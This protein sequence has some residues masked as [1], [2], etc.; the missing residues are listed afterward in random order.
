M[1]S[2]II[3]LCCAILFFLN[4]VSF[5]Q[6]DELK[7]TAAPATDK[8]N[9]DD[10]ATISTLQ[11][12]AESMKELKERIAEQ[13]LALDRAKT[14]DQKAAVKKDLEILNKRYK[15]LEHDLGRVAAGVNLED[16][17]QVGPEAGDFTWNEEL[18]ELLWPI[19]QELKNMTARP[20][21]IERLRSELLYYDKAMEATQKAVANLNKCIQ[22]TD[23]EEL[24]QRLEALKK[25]WLARKQQIESQGDVA[26][27]E[28]EERMRE[29]TSVVESAQTI[30]RSFFK[31]RGQNLAFAVI[32]FVC[33]LI[34]F[35][36]VHRLIYRFS[37][38]HHPAKRNFYIRV[39]DVVYHF[40]TFIAAGGAL[41]IVL[42]GSGDWVLLSLVI[43]FLLGILWT[44]RQ[45][46]VRFWEQIKLL[47]NLG[48][49]R[50]NERM[51]FNGL[52]W[53]VASINIYSHLENPEM[54]SQRIRLPLGAFIGLHSRPFD[55]RE[56]WF[57]CRLN[58]W[59]LLS[60][61]TFGRVVSQSPEMV[62]LVLLGGSRKTYPVGA[63][64]D[65]APENYSTNF[66][67][68][69]VFG[70]DY[71]HQAES[72][73]KIPEAMR[74]VIL[75]KLEQDE[76]EKYL[77]RLKVEFKSAGAS[78]LDVEVLAD[79]Q[80][81]AAQYHNRLERAIQRYC[82]DACN[83]HGWVIPFT[84]LTLHA[85][86][87]SSPRLASKGDSKNADNAPSP[88]SE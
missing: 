64:L 7:T 27:Y 87:E 2:K 78:S 59:V 62:Q 14:T 80:G 22:Y 11:T 51:V 45:G 36:V 26:R 24:R 49:V 74:E 6:T 13:E 9:N 41:V 66:R 30:V 65:L 34:G 55:D 69:S 17:D 81:E 63:F 73:Q 28:L 31:S 3:L 86:E 4:G 20:R 15:S 52:P 60:D 58:D 72:T 53:R 75:E 57:P 23:D 76:Y 40:A 79:F 25:N 44:A 21:E 70:V 82:V 61:G 38:L 83:Q 1:R 85:A 84:Q 68:R 29:K 8:I 35:R 88:E 54:E 67:I 33:V 77:I 16:T 56:P 46:L 42:Y 10:I 5:A 43:V 19:I 48:T 12:I 37:P 71:G 39:A 47:L 50:E 32:A 18:R